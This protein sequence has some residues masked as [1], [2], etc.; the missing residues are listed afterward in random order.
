M[1]VWMRGRW[2][3]E[4]FM[5]KQKSLIECEIRLGVAFDLLGTCLGPERE[6]KPIPDSGAR[7]D[8]TRRER[9]LDGSYKSINADWNNLVPLRDTKSFLL[10]HG[11][12]A[13]VSFF[14]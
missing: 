2:T 4:R 3:R 13:C 11:S 8:A 1:R 7:L 14:P 9:L 5:G 12:P 10:K 6:A